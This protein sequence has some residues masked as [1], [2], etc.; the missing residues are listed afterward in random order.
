M[1]CGGEGAEGEGRGEEEGKIENNCISLIACLGTKYML[2][3]LSRPRMKANWHC[4]YV[5][6]YIH[7]WYL[8]VSPA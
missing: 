5:L 3:P 8:A 7:G 4:L 2:T 6:C 1:G